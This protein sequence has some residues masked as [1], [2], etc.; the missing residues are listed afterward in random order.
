MS[1]SDDAY[2]ARQRSECRA[3]PGHVGHLGYRLTERGGLQEVGPAECPNGHPFRPG[4]VAAG[5]DGR[6]RYYACR[7]CD[8]ELLYCTCRADLFA[9]G[10]RTEPLE[11]ETESPTAS[12]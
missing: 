9:H 6:H 10:G 5:W 2:R 8:T 3:E 11:C 4:T 7:R 12:R 1:T